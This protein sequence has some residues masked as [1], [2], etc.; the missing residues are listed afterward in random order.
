MKAE[1][2]C[3]ANTANSPKAEFVKDWNRWFIAEEIDKI[4]S[5]LDPKIVWEMVGDSRLTGI[6][7]VEASFHEYG[8]D[9]GNDL[10]KMTVEGII[11]HGREACS[12]G[13]M[14]MADGTHYRFCDLLVFTN[15]SNNPKVKRV[16]S[17]VTE[18]KPEDSHE[19]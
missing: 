19:E 8:T 9:G 14:E 7:E 13:S 11:T 1:Y 6:P 17:F 2:I 10:L 16:T 18:V 12:Y 4:I 5:V 15:L 3:H